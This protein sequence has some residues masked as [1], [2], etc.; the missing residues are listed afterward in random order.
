MDGS[1]IFIVNGRAERR[2]VDGRCEPLTRSPRQV[3]YGRRDGVWQR[4]MANGVIGTAETLRKARALDQKLGVPIEYH[5]ERPGVWSAEF[6]D[7][8]EKR[9][10]LRAHRRVDMDAGYRDPA[11]GD[12]RGQ[13]PPEFGS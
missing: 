6:Q 13:Y 2:Y 10:W 5:A 11:P 1:Y 4:S 7:R 8:A 9:R 3:R 12:F